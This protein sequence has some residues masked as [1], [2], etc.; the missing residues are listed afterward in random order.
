MK[1]SGGF[2]AC[3][4]LVWSMTAASADYPA[5]KQGEWVARAF[6]F[7]TGEVM[8]ELRLHYTT[9]G[10]STGQPVLVLH[11][12]GQSAAAMLSPGF[13]GEL[14]GPGQPLDATKYYIIIPDSI[15]HG[16]SSKPSTASR[17]NFR[18]T[19]MPTWSKPNTGFSQ[20]GSAFAICGS[21]SAIQWAACKPGYGSKNI[22]PL[23][24]PPCRWPRNRPQ[25]PAATGCCDG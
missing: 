5:P 23:W 3:A 13:A 17:Q 11:G 20:K 7:H 18:T 9:I 21:S 6:K 1:I 2:G 10:E 14:F 19:T 4:L 15:G 25:W 22:R 12:T 16:Q 24:T 8:P